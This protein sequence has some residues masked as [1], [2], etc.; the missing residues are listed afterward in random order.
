MACHIIWDDHFG[1]ATKVAEGLAQRRQPVHLGLARRGARVGVVRGAEG[2][3]ENVRLADLAGGG[4][5]HRQRRPGVV[6]E[7]LLAGAVLLAHR[8]LEGTGV[9]AVMLDEL[10]IAV[11]RLVGMSGGVLLPQQLQ[12]HAFAT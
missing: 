4:V 3:D 6:D 2:R 11:G 7:Q 1:D 10:G 5:D 9:A 12:R 8:A